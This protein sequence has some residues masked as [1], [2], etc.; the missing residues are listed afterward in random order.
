MLIRLTRRCP[1]TLLSSLEAA[2]G[3][4][5]I[6]RIEHQTNTLAG[7]VQANTLA[8]TDVTNSPQ[9]FRAI[10]TSDS[11]PMKRR[12]GRRVARCCGALILTGALTCLLVWRAQ[13]APIH[14]GTP[15]VPRLTAPPPSPPP[16]EG[17]SPIN[18]ST[19]LLELA[20]SIN[21][22][23]ARG[24]VGALCSSCKALPP[25]DP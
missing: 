17:L 25:P 15:F 3:Q 11:A 9:S 14:Q 22:L 21:A 7:S 5:R 8:D 2:D 13:M 23:C 10:L 4:P 18:S 12:I 16:I 6:A 19:S 1:A 20:R 24:S